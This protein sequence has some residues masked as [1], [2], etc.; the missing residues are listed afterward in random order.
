MVI[1]SQLAL[2]SLISIFPDG[3]LAFLR[4][5]CSS[6]DIRG[7]GDSAVGTTSVFVLGDSEVSTPSISTNLWFKIGL[8][9]NV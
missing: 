9:V 7:V 5:S 2:I 1:E 4:I 8:V 3:F 6:R